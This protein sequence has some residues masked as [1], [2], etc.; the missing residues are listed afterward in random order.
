MWFEQFFSVNALNEGWDVLNL[1]DIIHFDISESKKSIATRY[2]VDW[3]WCKIVPTNCQ[4]AYK[5]SQSGVILTLH[6]QQ[7]LYLKLTMSAA[8]GI[9]SGSDIP[10]RCAGGFHCNAWTLYCRVSPGAVL[11]HPVFRHERDIVFFHRFH[12]TVR[13][14]RYS[15]GLLTAVVC[16]APDSALSQTSAFHTRYTLNRYPSA[17]APL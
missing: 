6:L 2:S 11:P 15:A 10:A 17:T 13:P 4:R 16:R 12:G 1:F 7:L 9:S 14:C 5:I 8:A 3:S